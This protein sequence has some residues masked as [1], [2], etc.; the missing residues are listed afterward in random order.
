[1]S[2]IMKVAIPPDGNEIAREWIWCE[3]L[4]YK[5]YNPKEI[6]GIFRAENSPFFISGLCVDDIIEAREVSDGGYSYYEF[7]EVSEHVREPLYMIYEVPEDHKKEALRQKFRVFC[8]AC[9]EHDLKPE[10]AVA[11]YV[12]VAVPK[13]T[14]ERSLKVILENAE[15]AGLKMHECLEEEDDS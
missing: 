15:T 10:G 2:K 4:D 12:V 13:G 8:Q 3:F 9:K 6:V 11:G 14:Y 7:V 5:V 1:M